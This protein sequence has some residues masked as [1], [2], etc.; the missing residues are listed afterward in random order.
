M[1][2]RSG[3]RHQSL[4]LWRIESK[5]L[6]LH[7][8]KCK[9]RRQFFA[10][11]TAIQEQCPEKKDA[12]KVAARVKKQKKVILRSYSG[13]YSSV[14]TP[15][16]SVLSVFS[17]DRNN[18]EY[19]HLSHSVI[20]FITFTSENPYCKISFTPFCQMRPIHIALV[21]LISHNAYLYAKHQNFALKLKP[22]K[23]TSTKINVNLDRCQQ[24]QG[25][26]TSS[27]K[28]LSSDSIPYNVWRKV[29]DILPTKI[30]KDVTMK[31]KK[32]RNLLTMKCKKRTLNFVYRRIY[33]I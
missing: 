31:K 29:V 18:S 11:V 15:Y 33:W 5:I 26:V 19:G 9:K 27:L 17:T 3:K 30:K 10:S 22:L 13:P 14:F 8:R 16:L 24:S 21:N 6:N 1:Y 2:E 23:S 25:D 32:F 12:K 4:S 7:R 20:T 28:L